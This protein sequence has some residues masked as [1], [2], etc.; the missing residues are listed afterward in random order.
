MRALIK[1]NMY[2]KPKNNTAH[3]SIRLSTRMIKLYVKQ[4]TVMLYNNTGNIPTTN[5]TRI[6]I[7][8]ICVEASTIINNNNVLMYRVPMC[9]CIVYLS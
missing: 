1:Y 4:S 9:T 8:N 2:T 5:L 3:N 6:S 7:Y